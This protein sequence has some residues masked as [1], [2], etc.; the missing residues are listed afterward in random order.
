M[1]DFLKTP[2]I[3]TL[4]R[5]GVLAL[6]AALATWLVRKGLASTVDAEKLASDLVEPLVVLL[7]IAYDYSRSRATAQA[8]QKIAAALSLPAGSTSA[9]VAAVIKE[10]ARG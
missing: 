8:E 5:R 7:V 9:D 6:T 4:I 10:Q 2:I 3:K 1:L